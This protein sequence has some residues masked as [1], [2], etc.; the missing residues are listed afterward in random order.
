M[1]HSSVFSFLP[2]LN[3]STLITI[4]RFFFFRLKPFLLKPSACAT[5]GVRNLI[6]LNSSFPLLFEANKRVL[7]PVTL[8]ADPTPSVQELSF[9]APKSFPSYNGDVVGTD[10]LTGFPPRANPLETLPLGTAVH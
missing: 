10:P 6:P 8:H 1:N 2:L 5:E 3:F 7:F 9:F 4:R